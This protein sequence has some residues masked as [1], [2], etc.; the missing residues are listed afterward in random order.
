M[1]RISIIFIFTLSIYF[2]AH[3]QDVPSIYNLLYN[4]Y[5]ASEEAL[6]KLICERNLESSIEK[7]PG[8]NYA[9]SLAN[10]DTT[11]SVCILEKFMLGDFIFRAE[12]KAEVES[13]TLNGFG[14]VF[15]LRDSAHYYYF[16]L[17]Y[18]PQNDLL[19]QL[20][21]IN[22]NQ[23]NLLSE[24]LMERTNKNGWDQIA[25][26]RD[27]VTTKTEIYINHMNVPAD[28]INDRIFILGS[29][30]YKVEPA[31]KLFVDN[32][33]IWGPTVLDKIE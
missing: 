32:V 25:I 3:S 13:D 1:L 26:R 11:S 2:P 9:L 33:K 14:F 31:V 28:A 20:W 15:G 19:F 21:L 22:G 6:E 4:E 18:E 7:L 29:V 17:S 23:K 10:T 24:G 8:N 16:R 27:I 12:V 30:G 5:Y